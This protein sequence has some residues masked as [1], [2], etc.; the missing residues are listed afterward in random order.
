MSLV[1]HNALEV[2]MCQATFS[3]RLTTATTV[4]NETLPAPGHIVC[5]LSPAKGKARYRGCM[6]A[7]SNHRGMSIDCR[8][9]IFLFGSD[10]LN[11]EHIKL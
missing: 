2:R 7:V 3:M 1:L 10:G 4:G 8:T 11:N 5:L 6:K 9:V